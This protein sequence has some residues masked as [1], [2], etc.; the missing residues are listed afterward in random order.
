MAAFRVSAL[1]MVTGSLISVHQR[2]L[3]QNSDEGITQTEAVAGL[4]A[5]RKMSPRTSER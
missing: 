1:V 4:E 5:D 2:P 3:T